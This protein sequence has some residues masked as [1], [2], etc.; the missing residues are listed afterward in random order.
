MF[1][2][3]PDGTSRP[4]T[5]E[6]IELAR[7]KKIAQEAEFLEM[8]KNQIR[9]ERNALISKSDWRVVAAIDTGVPMSE[10]WVAYRQAL[11]DIPA[12]P[13]FPDNIVW[14]TQPE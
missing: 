8:R 3:M 12:Q 1:I 14:P 10:A 5:E 4:A 9:Y 11:R 7:L 13:T 2:A 6:E